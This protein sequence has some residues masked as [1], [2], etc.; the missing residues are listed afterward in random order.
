MTRKEKLYCEYLSIRNEIYTVKGLG[1]KVLNL[2][3]YINTSDFQRSIC[4]YKVYELK[5]CI[6]SAHRELEKVKKKA[7]RLAWFKTDE[8]KKLLE[9]NEKELKK[10]SEEQEELN[11]SGRWY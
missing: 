10:L 2:D 3:E 9:D 8:G 5:D 6:K 1:E 7:E 11:K 4:H